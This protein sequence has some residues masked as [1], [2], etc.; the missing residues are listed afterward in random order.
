MQ[1]IVI[2]GFIMAAPLAYI[3]IRD[4]ARYLLKK[5]AGGP[6]MET[7]EIDLRQ[8]RMDLIELDEMRRYVC[9]RCDDVQDDSH[10]TCYYI[11]GN[12]IVCGECIDEDIE[13]MPDWERR[14][15]MGAE[16]V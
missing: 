16:R 9:A 5:L 8:E 7:P 3:V 13:N 11:W 6:I 14:E 1:L 12:E 2:V 4:V 10:D 15:R